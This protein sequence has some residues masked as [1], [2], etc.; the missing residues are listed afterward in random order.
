MLGRVSKVIDLRLLRRGVVSFAIVSP[1]LV[2]CVLLGID[3]LP[4]PPLD[5]GS[6]VPVPVP[7][8]ESLLYSFGRIS[9][10]FPAVDLLAHLNPAMLDQ[11]LPVIRIQPPIRSER[12]RSAF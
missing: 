6:T 11:V 2:I 7:R 3:T 10:G 5:R 4:S 1:I 12:G 9:Y 8:A